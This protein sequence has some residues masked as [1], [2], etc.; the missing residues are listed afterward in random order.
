MS[1]ANININS[2]TPTE[3]LN[4]AEEILSLVEARLLERSIRVSTV[5]LTETKKPTYKKPTYIKA[6]GTNEIQRIIAD[7]R[8]EIKLEAENS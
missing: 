1:S 6:V 5:K 3:A 4:L 2:H 7:I 8:E